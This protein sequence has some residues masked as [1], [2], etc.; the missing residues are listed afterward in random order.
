MLYTSQRKPQAR[1][2]SCLN[3]THCL[4]NA[5]GSC[6]H[7]NNAS[8]QWLSWQTY[9]SGSHVAWFQIDHGNQK[10]WHSHCC[11]SSFSHRW[12]KGNHH[13]PVLQI[14]ERSELRL[15][16]WRVWLRGLVEKE[17]E[18]DWEGSEVM[19]MFLE[20]WKYSTS[21]L[22]VGY[23]S[24]C[25]C[26]NWSILHLA[27]VHFTVCK[28]YFHY[29]KAILFLL[30]EANIGT[31]LILLISNLSFWYQLEK[32][33]PEV[34]FLAHYTPLCAVVDGTQDLESKA[35]IRSPHHPPLPPLTKS[36]TFGK[37]LDLSEA[38]LLH[39]YN[40]G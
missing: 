23:I 35:C 1:S 37:S 5:E 27:S 29:K 8:V 13:K 39:L 31:I 10:R 34:P 21:W 28:L 14:Y 25:I 2:Q 36:K 7:R 19:E 6:C 18:I 22:H 38:L 20:W 3:V 16:G 33:S 17:G 30:Q 15:F 12:P 11:L 32:G 40:R 9:P 26:Q 24:I 4:V